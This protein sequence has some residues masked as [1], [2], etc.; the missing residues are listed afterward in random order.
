MLKLLLY[1]FIV[2]YHKAAFVIWEKS[3]LRLS[4]YQTA[5]V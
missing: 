3:S 5:K 1:Y 4:L 2:R